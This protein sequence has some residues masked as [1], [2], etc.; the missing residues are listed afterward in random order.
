MA[1]IHNHNKRMPVV[2][3]PED[4]SKWLEPSPIQDFAFPY[5]VD[6][7]ANPINLT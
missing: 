6:L 3:K 1:V 4:E 5:S 7:I 2:P